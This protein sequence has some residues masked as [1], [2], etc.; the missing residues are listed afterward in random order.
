MQ[1]RMRKTQS[2][3]MLLQL[4]IVVENY[5]QNE[6]KLVFRKK[7]NFFHCELKVASHLPYRL[8]IHTRAEQ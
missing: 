2:L 4:L 3:C 5:S 1:V 7:H 6:R 8:T